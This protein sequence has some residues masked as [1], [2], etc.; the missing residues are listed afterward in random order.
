[1]NRAGKIHILLLCRLLCILD[2]LEDFYGNLRINVGT[3]VT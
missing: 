1:M 3:K 2:I